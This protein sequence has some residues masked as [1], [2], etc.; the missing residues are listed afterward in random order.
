MSAAA[1]FAGVSVRTADTWLR[2][3]REEEERLERGEPADKVEAKYLNFL[4]ATEA[5][6]AHAVDIA[7]RTVL[8]DIE[9]DPQGGAMVL[10]PP[11]PRKL[12]WE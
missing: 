5:A 6:S 10:D 8:K 2:R 11:I 12:E 1:P 9:H 4:H 7:I 3:G